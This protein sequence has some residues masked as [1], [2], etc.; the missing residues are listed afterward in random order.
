MMAGLEGTSLP[1]AALRCPNCS[2]PFEPAA[3]GTLAEV[4]CAACQS[5]LSVC[6]FRG[7]QAP[8]KAVSTASG[9]QAAEG[10]AVCF[11]HPEKRAECSC[12]RCGR[13]ICALC[14][15]PLAGRHL[16]P[17]CLDSSKLPELVP[18]KF[19]GG[20]FSMLCGIVPIVFFPI[21]MGCFYVLPITGGAAIG[22]GLWSWRKPGS[23]VQGPRHGMA[24]LGI[25]GGILQI[26]FL[27]GMV[28]LMYYAIK[29][30]N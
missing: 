11:F 17:K 25:I 6:T 18:S 9:E 8:P 2:L 4:Q 10:E 14:D 1:A 7:L 16:C 13:F 15:M 12:E 29:H 24:V 21:F 23:V 28:G 30:G 3:V 22:F 27:I 20:Y 19:V 5:T 26:G